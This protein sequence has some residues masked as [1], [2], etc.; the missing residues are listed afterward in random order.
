MTPLEAIRKV[1]VAC[2]ASAYDVADCGGNKCVGGKGGE[3]EV[4]YFFPFRLGKGRPSVKTIRKFCLE[5]MGGRSKLVAECGSD[6]PLHPYRFGK[7]P[8][9]AGLTNKGSFKPSVSRDFLS[10]NRSSD[11]NE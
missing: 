3:K 6:C 1:C 2:V 4:C 11:T 8:A 10:Q 7:S 5:C 9:R